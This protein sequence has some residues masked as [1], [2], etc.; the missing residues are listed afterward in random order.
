MLYGQE[1]QEWL[2]NT[3]ETRCSSGTGYCIWSRRCKSRCSSGTG[4]YAILHILRQ[5]VLMAQQHLR[6]QMQLRNRVLYLE[7][8]MQESV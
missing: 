8:E 6:H 5:M 4:Y 3:F 1:W 2:S 7:P